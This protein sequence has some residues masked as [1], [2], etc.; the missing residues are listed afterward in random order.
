M[1]PF[2]PFI[3]LCSLVTFAVAT[4]SAQ[5]YYPVRPIRIVTSAPGGGTDFASRQLAPELAASLGQNVI[6][7]NRAGGAVQVA[8]AQPN[9]YTLLLAGSVF[10]IEPLFQKVSYDP[11]ANFLS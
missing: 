2:I 6:V 8:Q 1:P 3:G 10:W 11:M 7:E 9:G 5:E 4:V